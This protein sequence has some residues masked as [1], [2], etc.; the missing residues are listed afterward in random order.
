MTQP[1]HVFCIRYDNQAILASL[2]RRR[3]ARLGHRND[4]FAGEK[5]DISDMLSLSA[6]RSTEQGGMSDLLHG[7]SIVQATVETGWDDGI[8]RVAC[9][10]KLSKGDTGYAG[11]GGGEEGGF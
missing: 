3:L 10:P 6:G 7:W 9:F 8:T 2:D 4:S 11:F 1:A 5:R